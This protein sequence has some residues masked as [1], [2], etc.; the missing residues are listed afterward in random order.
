MTTHK[1]ININSIELND[2]TPVSLILTSPPYPMIEMWDEVFSQQNP[3]IKEALNDGNGKIAWQ[4]MSEI[5]NN[6]LSISVENLIE[7]GFLVVNIGD[8]TRSINGKFALYGTHS[9]IDYHCV[10]N[11]NLTKL[12]PIL[13][14]KPSNKA[15]KYMGSG[16]LPAGAY[17]TYEHEYILIYRKGDKRKF[18]KQASENRMKSAIFWEERNVWFS[19]IWKGLTGTSQ[20]LSSES[21]GR[22]A[23]FP[24]E[25][26]YRIIAMYSCQGDTVFDPFSGLGTTSLAAMHLGRNSIGVDTEKS[27]IELSINRLL[28]NKDWCNAYTERRKENHIKFVDNQSK[29]GK[30]LKYKNKNYLFPVTSNQETDIYFPIIKDITKKE[31]S[32]EIN[33]SQSGL[34]GW[35]RR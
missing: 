24:H 12:P 15:T 3:K 14:S 30:P 16:M 6:I 32:V 21:R 5:V 26:A 31:S 7:G 11:L 10:N 13:W 28:S 2:K 1:F 34:I 18:D 20:K 29:L 35:P 8:A 23:S 27:L 33:Y 22:N 19:D 25:L 4:L 9:V 17:V